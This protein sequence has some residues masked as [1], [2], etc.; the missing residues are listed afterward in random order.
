MWR[1]SRN[2]FIREKILKQR[3]C[4]FEQGLILVVVVEELC[5]FVQYSLY[6]AIRFHAAAPANVA[7]VEDIEGRDHRP[8]FVEEE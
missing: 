5:M 3:R 7:A 2:K 4:L 8:D 6:V 1:G